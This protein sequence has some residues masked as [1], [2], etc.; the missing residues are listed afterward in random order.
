MEYVMKLNQHKGF[1]IVELLIVIVVIAI[2]AAITVVAYNGVQNRGRTSAGAANATLIARKAEMFNT[3]YA[4]YPSYCMLATNTTNSVTAAPTGA[5]TG[6]NGCVAGATAVSAE[7]R[8][9]NVNMLSSIDVT[10][11][12]SANGTVVSYKR[13]TSNGSRIGYWDSTLSSPAPQY[14]YIGDTSSCS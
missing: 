6:V 12:T 13:C 4:T 3:L 2:L 9:D 8:I 10:G 5:G 14:K 7:V 11:T 1:T